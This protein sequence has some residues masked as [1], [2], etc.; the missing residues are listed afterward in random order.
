MIE[1]T[2]AVERVFV[3]VVVDGISAALSLLSSCL[4]RSSKAVGYP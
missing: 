3:L 2:T 1:R 4:A